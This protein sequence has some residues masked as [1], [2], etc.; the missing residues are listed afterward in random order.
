MP[1]KKGASIE[2]SVVLPLARDVAVRLSGGQNT[3][4]EPEPNTPEW[5][6]LQ[7]DALYD[8]LPPL[9]L[10]VENGFKKDALDFNLRREA[11]GVVEELVRV[12]DA[13]AEPSD[14]PDKTGSL[15]MSLNSLNGVSFHIVLSICGM[16]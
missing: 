11:W 7:T 8:P 1:S 13:Y 16:V 5:Y 2:W 10:L 3:S 4:E 6:R 14:Y 9:F 15:H 12:G